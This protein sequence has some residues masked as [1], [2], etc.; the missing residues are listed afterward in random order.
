[1]LKGQFTPKSRMHVVPPACCVFYLSGLFWCKWTGFRYIGCPFSNI[2][3]LDGTW[4]VGHKAMSLSRNH[5]PLTQDNPQTLLW[6][7][8]YRNYFLFVS[9]HRRS[10]T[11]L[12]TLHTFLS[13]NQE[14]CSHWALHAT[15][16]SGDKSHKVQS[17]WPDASCDKEMTQSNLFVHWVSAKKA[18]KWGWHS[19]KYW[20]H[21]VYLLW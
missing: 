21:W 17:K 1:M 4:I 11:V 16:L 2:M 10:C 20:T 18:R 8:S 9:S 13:C 12:F 6:A 14:S 15:L 19:Y 3:E 5:D 7:P